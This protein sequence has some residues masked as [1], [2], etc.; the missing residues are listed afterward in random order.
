MNNYNYDSI[1]SLNKYYKH[2]MLVWEQEFIEGIQKWDGE[3]IAA[4]KTIILKLN[5]KYRAQR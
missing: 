3:V 1:S 4:Q 2:K 5:R